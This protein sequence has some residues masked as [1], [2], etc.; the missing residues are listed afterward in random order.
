MGWWKIDRLSWKLGVSVGLLVVAA[1]LGGVTLAHRTLDAEVVATVRRDA[2][3]ETRLIREALEHQML[4]KES[5]LIR[6]MVAGFA[7][8]DGVERVMILDRKGEVRYSSDPAV[9]T[10][11]FAATSPTCQVCHQRPAK[12]RMTSTLL[13][14]ARG[15]VL[16]CVQPIRNRK[17]CHGCHEAEHRINGVIIVDI[18]VGQTRRA[19]AASIAS[20]PIPAI[21]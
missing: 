16:R 7:S 2:Q 8:R 5:D 1:L 9:R 20:G 18:P 13:E 6:R 3:R 14:L 15:T 19:I 4:D 17:A 10:R 21:A 11:H 12:Q